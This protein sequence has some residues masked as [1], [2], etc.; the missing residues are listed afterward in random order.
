MTSEA[1][2]GLFLAAQDSPATADQYATSVRDFGT[3][4]HREAPLDGGRVIE[5][6]RSV[7][8]GQANTIVEGYR[9]NLRSRELAPATINARL[10]SIKS[11]VGWLKSKG[12]IDW[13]LDVKGVKAR[14]YRETSGPGFAAF[15]AML[16]QID[17]RGDDLKARRDR[18]I[19]RLLH[20][21][22]LRRMEVTALDLADV[23]LNPRANDGSASLWIRGKGRHDDEQITVPPAAAKALRDWIEVR[24]EEPGPLFC[25]L[26]RA[27]ARGRLSET[28]VY[29]MVVKYG[30]Q[31]GVRAR[32]HGLRHSGITR[33]A[34]KTGGNLVKVAAFS[35]HAKIETVKIYVD[36]L[37][38]D[39]GAVARLVSED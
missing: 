22:A 34:E 19:V 39:A 26:D 24:G 3:F 2:Y 8:V 13:R 37:R 38:D 23:G 29:R 25:N 36:N 27:N 7:T 33:A 12:L 32:P 35:R 4:L 16:A 31:V 1:W 14:A 18:A 20:D 9:V 28:S 17:V 15:K 5:V 10:A 11:L 21:L 6:L 30:Q